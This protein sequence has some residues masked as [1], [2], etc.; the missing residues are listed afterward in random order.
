VSDPSAARRLGL[1]WA[2]A[3]LLAG[4]QAVL[5]VQTARDKSD[6]IDEATYIPRAAMLFTPQRDGGMPRNWA[7]PQWGYALALRLAA[8]EALPL[9]S[10]RYLLEQRLLW[11]ATPEQ[12]RRRLL[13][14]RLA[15][16]A[17]TVGAGLLLWLAA[18]RFGEAAALLTLALW[19]FSPT[20][21]AHGSLATLDGWAAAAVA[22]FAWATVRYVERPGLGRAAVVGVVAGL[23][24][25]TKLPALGV[26]PVGL[27]AGGWAL[28]RRRSH[29]ERWPWPKLV[30][31]HTAAFAGAAFLA[32]WASYGFTVGPADLSGSLSKLRRVPGEAVGLAVPLPFPG[33]I[34]SVIGQARYGGAG[35][36][37][38]L[39]GRVSATGW[40]YFYC[41]ALGL[42][43]TLGAQA[44]ILLCLSSWLRKRPTAESVRI[45]AA[46]L[47]YPLLIFLV[48]SAAP[49][50]GGIR[51]LLPAFPLAMLWAGRGLGDIGAAF[52]RAGRGAAWLAVA[53]G[54]AASL[55]LHPDHLMFFNSWA[56][57]PA[58]GPR[59]LIQS[60]DWGQDQRGL[61]EWQRR[62]G[63]RMIYYTYYTGKPELWGISYGDPPCTPRR[64]VYALHAIEVHRPRRLEP[65]CLDWLT[66][67]PPD[68][69]IGG[70]IYL[71]FVD[72]ERIERL[73]AERA[74]A[75]PFWR[76]GPAPAGPS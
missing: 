35:K 53:A 50:Q 29:E 47:A 68:Q 33:W 36:R 9:P 42:K 55:S 64:G 22:A 76:S 66:V 65:G 58:G 26:I 46:L 38:Y 28:F 60:D 7:L 12:L 67:E 2:A 49:S 8:P 27:A 34:E 1:A 72:K 21:L 59:Y 51:Y 25:S 56:G 39:M 32:L 43:T 23:L 73:K 24:A 70:T 31:S 40:W 5:L 52:G 44:L 6:T 10:D 4:L 57:G 69:R 45:G 74:T 63:F 13:A 11:D 75:T 54:A 71:Y 30:A 18:R 48:M 41:V 37:S 16:V 17:V 61:G 3:L 15:T 19:C 20:V 14:V 62:N